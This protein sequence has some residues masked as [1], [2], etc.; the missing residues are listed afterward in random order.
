MASKFSRNKYIAAISVALTSQVISS[1]TVLAQEKQTFSL[2]EVVVSARRISEN[3]QDVPTAVSV[4]SKDTIEAMQIDG[5]L[6]VGQTVPNLYIQ[7]QGGAPAAPQMNIRGITNGSLNLQVDS[8]IGL[9]IDGVYL[10]RPGAASFDIADLDQVEVLR[11]PQGTLFGRNSTGG[12]INLITAKPSG[13]LDGKLVAG[14][15]NFN[16]RTYRGSLNLPEFHGLSAKINVL[17]KEIEGDV[18]NIATKSTFTFPEP[19]GAIKTADRGGDD[20]TEAFSIA[21]RYTGI[22]R[23]T[24]DYRYDKT[25]WEG[26]KA[27]RQVANS[28]PCVDFAT[29]TGQCAFATPGLLT[30]VH[31]LSLDF[32]YRDELSSPLETQADLDISGHG[33][34][35]EYELLDSM[36]IKYIFGDRGYDL[37]SGGNQVWGAHEHYDTFGTFGTA[38]DLW[39]PLFALRVEDQDQTSHELQL[40]G[41]HESFDWILGGFRFREEGAVNNP[42]YLFSTISSTTLNPVSAAAFHYFVGQNVEVENT[43]T[44]YYGHLTYHFGDFD[45]S[46][47]IRHTEDEREELVIAAGLFG[48]I[49]PGNQGFDTK[50]SNTDYS[51]SMKY[52]FRQDANV[53]YKYA[54]GYVSGG[55]LF[56]NEFDKEEVDSHEIGLKSD[57]FDSRLRV[58]A[59]IFK[60]ERSDTQIEGFTA[61]GYF[62]GQGESVDSEGIELEMTY[63]P[64]DGMTVNFN[65]GYVDV[66]S[67][68]DLR[69]FQ[70]P[71]TAY[72]GLKYDFPQLSGGVAP[73][74]RLDASWRDDT[75]RLACKA[76]SD[77]I[78][79]TDTCVGTPDLE[80]DEKAVLKATTLLG[81][82][83]DFDDIS[84][85]G[86]MTGKLS[87]WGRNLLDENNKE[88]GFT[89]GGPT[90]TNTF[91][92][93]RTYG[94]DFTL[95][96]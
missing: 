26:T 89:L 79:A 1:G 75:W 84:L 91:M 83:V 95:R 57:W 45:L 69:T 94:V 71:H 54:T 17:K 11:G 48:A 27:I 63:L 78:P 60:M 41:T 67:S 65:Y 92:R 20:D 14:F 59:A 34:T 19:F 6:S 39:T 96:F 3:L 56:S 23:L 64:F 36:S 66:D 9:Y 52:N 82:V 70:P 47:G 4:I 81:L 31:P 40:I 35:L 76:G 16:A 30:E 10:G 80:L 53:Y 12:A 55:T 49:I 24:V 77:Q 22:D 44:A 18:K 72:L 93:P 5:F 86:D 85:G 2:E 13:E 50:S 73:S 46:G 88:F 15:G 7:K 42:I 51:V 8:G 90:L 38:G 28:G 21:L 32:N 74:V 29:T 58:N 43:S 37:G 33:L 25:K 61:I 87:L 62:M 68:G